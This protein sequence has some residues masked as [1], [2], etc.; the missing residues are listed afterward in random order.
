M[1]AA[2]VK[3]LDDMLL[4]PAGCELTARH[5]KVLRTWGISEI[6]VKAG[7]AVEELDPLAKLGPERAAKLQEEI[8]SLFW[9]FE[10]ANTVQQELFK[11]MLRRKAAQILA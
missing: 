10:E 6:Q 4:I 3:N 1:V 11:I 2:D 8:K 7:D 5:V 9:R